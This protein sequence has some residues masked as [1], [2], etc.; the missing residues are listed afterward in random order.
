MQNQLIIYKFYLKNKTKHIRKNKR[1]T[2][3]GKKKKL[4]INQ[5]V[6]VPSLLVENNFLVTINALPI[7]PAATA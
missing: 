5:N 1:I 4:R 7:V 6:F 3:E 2:V